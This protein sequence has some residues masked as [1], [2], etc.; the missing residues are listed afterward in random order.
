MS[1]TNQFLAG[2]NPTN[3]ASAFRVISAVQQG[4]DVLVTSDHGGV[5]I[6]M[7]CRPLLATGMVVTRPTLLT[8]AAQSSYW[9][10]GM[11]QTITRTPA[12]SPMAL[13]VITVFGLCRKSLFP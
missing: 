7:P 11:S 2:I 1:N 10:V 12:V 5:L 3:P 6:P 4:S 9:A 13:R 8:L